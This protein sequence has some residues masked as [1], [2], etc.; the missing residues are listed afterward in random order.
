MKP[1]IR[2]AHNYDRHAASLASATV[3]DLPSR[4]V[5]SEK[6]DA[7]INVIVS[8]FQITGHVP[9]R[10]MPPLELDFADIFDFQSAQ[11]TMREAQIAFAA[12]PAVTRA[13]FHNDPGAFVQ[14]CSNADNLEELR[15]M[16]LA[17]PAPK[18]DNPGASAD[19]SST[20]TS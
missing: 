19:S 3:N 6:D 18:P 8:R 12:L 5:Q 15:T 11:D 20:S 14:F 2:S 10:S 7:D 13:R 1:F 17:N 4:A 9:A 16:G